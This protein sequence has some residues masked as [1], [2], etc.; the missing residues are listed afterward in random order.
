MDINVIYTLN[1]PNT[2]KKMSALKDYY[3]ILNISKTATN[4]DIKKSYRNLARKYHPDL[5]PNNKVAEEKFK[6][7]SEAYEVLSSPDKRKKFDDGEFNVNPH[8]YKTGA[9]YSQTQANNN[10][11]YQDIFRENF[12]DFNFEDMFKQQSYQNRA[13]RGEDQIYQMEVEFKEAALGNEKTFTLPNGNKIAAKIPAGIRTGQK[14]K[15]KERGGPGYN[16]GPAGDVYIEIKVKPSEQFKVDGYD[17]LVETPIL[18]STALIGG[19]VRVPTLE[20]AVEINIPKNTNTDTKLR[21]KGKGIKGK[22]TGDL[23]AL[24]K[25]I[26]PPSITPELKAAV[27]DWQK[28]LDSSDGGL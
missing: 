15:L 10:S 23:Y 7:V 13:L 28:T 4:D 27:T 9:S 25:I 21:I 16:G 8:D 11:R 2:G 26:I 22:T 24:I 12:G 5:N 19:K 1:L 20:G 17:L 14:I 18:F 3:K 6:E